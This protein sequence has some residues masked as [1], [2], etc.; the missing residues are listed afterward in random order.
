MD[1]TGQSPNRRTRAP[2]PLDPAQLQELALSYAARFATSGARLEAYLARKLRERGWAG[3]EA[4]DPAAVAG[5][6]AQLGYVDDAAY[7]RTRADG[8]L[9]RGYGARR[10]NQAL[11][12]AGIGQGLRAEVLPGQGAAMRAA[13]VLARKRRL[14][15]FGA[16]LP[17]RAAH[18]KQLAVMVRAGHSHAIAARIIGAA[19]IDQAEA[20]LAEAE[21]ED[22]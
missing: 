7:A 18:E 9:R 10:V 1:D 14:G 5:R 13:L 19:S 6:M 2:R 8:L 20:L 11:G 22:C 3:D 21:D 16:Q 15:P 12:A 4:P 17:D